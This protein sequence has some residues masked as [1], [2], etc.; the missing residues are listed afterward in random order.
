MS[1]VTFTGLLKQNIREYAIYLAALIIVVYFTIATK[2]LFLSDVNIANLFNQSGYI[3]VLSIGM[4]LVIIIR[5]IDLSVGFTSGFLGAVVAVLMS[6]MGVPWFLA[7]IIVIVLGA[8]LG[9]FTGYL[10]AGIGIPAF[11]A[12][13]AGMFI[14]RGALIYTTKSSTIFTESNAFNS[15]SNGAIPSLLEVGGYSLST[16]ILGILAVIALVINE[17]RRRKSDRDHDIE[18]LPMRYVIAKLV[19][20]S[21]V[22]AFITEKF[23]GRHGFT[24]TF[25]IV[26]VV[27]GLFNYITMKTKFGRYVYA[28]GGNPEAAELSGINVK[29]ITILVFITMGS[30]AA[31][32]GIMFTS[33][34]QSATPTA[35][36]LFELF[37]IAG[38]YV[39]GVS[40]GGGIGK[41]INSVIGAY[42]MGALTNGMQLLGIGTSVQY[43]IFG[44]VLSAAVI[45]DIK[46][47]E[48]KK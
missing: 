43:M 22:I 11:I 31:L 14:F 26:V 20:I 45:F 9:A 23:A 42:V 1:K 40:A 24:W 5:H 12:T 19:F 25:I 7:I 32:A 47:R 36:T 30:L 28:V 3:A 34:L 27:A 16:I 17:F 18:V 4:T 13:L 6:N 2:G 29:K 35:G 44:A 37:A 41:I 10:V 21:L 39:G 46:T 33:R 15:I 8:I 48:I 38:C